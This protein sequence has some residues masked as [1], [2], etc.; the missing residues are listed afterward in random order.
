MN[1]AAFILLA[2]ILTAYVLLDGYDLGVGVLHLFVARSDD[3]RAASLA[4]IG[5]FWSGN[6]VVLVAAGG[7][8]FALF[9]RAYAASF[10]GFYLPIMVVFWLL[11]GRGVAIELRGHFAS[12]LWH[13]F[14]DV[15]FAICSIL[16]AFVF[17]VALGNVL[18]GVPLDSHGYFSGTF[19]FLFNWYAILV[20]FLALAALAQHGAAFSAWRSPALAVRSER[21]ARGLWIVVLVL[22]VGTTWATLRLHPT[23]LGPALW[24]APCIAVLALAA[25]Q[26]LKDRW[27]R[28]TASAVFLSG[29]MFAAAATLYPYLLPSYPAGSGGLDIYNSSLA[30]HAL[31]TGIIIFSVGFIAVAI[32][33][34]LAARKLLR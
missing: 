26:L 20:G 13:G 34:T 14:W 31:G 15:T 29:L 18:R 6:E 1:E 12:D 10:S 11:I 21:A 16:L 5:P 22:F 17:G 32:Y 4:T 8:M 7:T 30:T 19:A 27:W 23:L 25:M 24:I 3:E 33:G 9:P 2:V 28:F